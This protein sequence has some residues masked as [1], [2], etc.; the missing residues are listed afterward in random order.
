MKRNAGGTSRLVLVLAGMAAALLA[1]PDAHACPCSLWGPETVP[2]NL[3]ANDPGAVEL[4]VR[5]RA[6]TAGT[7]SAIRFYKATDNAGPHVGN[8][9]TNDGVLLATVTFDAETA[10]GWQQA[11]LASPV[12][13][14]ANTLYVVS[15]HA[16]AGHYAFDSAYFAAPRENGPLLAPSSAEAG[17]N[18]VFAYGAGSAFPGNTFNATN[19]WVDVVFEDGPPDPSPPTVVSTTPPAGAT[20]V[21]VGQDVLVVFSKAMD[22]AS[23]G[24]ATFALRDAGGDL[25][26]ASVSYEPSAFRAA[27]RPSSPLAYSVTYTATVKGGPDGVR[28]LDGQPLAADHTWSFTTVPPPADEGPGGPILIVT[29]AASPFSRYY[30]EILATE[31]FNSYLAT[32]VSHLTPSLL[33]AHDVL[34]LAEMTLTADQVAMLTDW[35]GTG[36]NLVAM[37]PDPQLAGLLGLSATDEV[38][39]DAYLRVDDATAPGRGIVSQTIQYHGPADRY[40]ASGATAAATLYSDATTVTA[41]PAVTLRSVGSNG[42]HA[43]AFVYDLARSVVYTHQGNPAWAGTERDG[44]SPIR[45]NDLFFPSYV[46]LDRV[47]IPQADEQQRLL[48]NVIHEMQLARRPLPRFWYLPGGRKAVLVHALDDHNTSSG[49]RETFDKLEA[50]SPAGC[51]VADWQ[52]LRATSWGYTGISLTDAQAAAYQLRGFELGVHVNT[53]CQDWTPASLQAAFVSDLQAYSSTFPSVAPQRSNR[54]HCI[55]W[56]DWA[57]Q[58]KVE[59]G[60]GIRYD[61]NYYYWPGSW[62]AGRPGFFTG[63]GIPMR[64]ADLDG[65]RIDVYQGVSQLVN[66]N[67]LVYPDAIATMID[68]AQGPEGYYGVLGTHDDYRDTAFSDGMIT[69][70]LAKGV[71]VVSAA[72]MLEWLDGRN[73]SSIAGGAFANGLLTFQVSADPRARNLVLMVPTQAA[74]GAL[75]DIKR[76]NTAVPFTV[77]TVKGVEYALVAAISGTYT[78]QFGPSAPTG[79]FTLWPGSATPTHPAATDDP[80][81]VELGVR[82]VSDVN[83]FVKGIRFYKGPGNTGSHRA[84]LWS[85][86]GARLATATFTN[87]SATGWQQVLFATPVPI[88]A[89]T[90]YV[91][92]YLARRGRYAYDEEYFNTALDN[93]PLH[94]LANGSGGN[95]VYHYGTGAVFPTDTYRATNYWVDV[96]FDTQP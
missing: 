12:A 75:T 11:Q 92:S 70:A 24:P 29:S 69:T 9:W 65:T 10:S 1:A 39:S 50:R 49:T 81:A 71:A 20:G 2:A 56:S 26:P 90:V 85:G 22:A 63:S 77:E 18:G 60:R 37:R 41:N 84:D 32:D 23:I 15:Y 82:F 4:G 6:A 83:G 46:D 74:T 96:V 25:V 59:L 57:T 27:L 14:N 44:S 87:E 3:F 61:M 5:F 33:Q 31:G 68:R 16:P 17:G 78:A 45:P 40:L 54:T 43:A 80:N 35:V 51:S 94:A 91:A 55:A 89:G 34:I 88:S 86:T 38:L 79:P 19:Y 64:F 72:Q 8:L 66:E 73:A 42:G 58:P 95:G 28:D 93:P 13:I 53:G 7:I 52:C 76:D 47:A 67:D 48:A 62:V 30:A 36:G 21:G